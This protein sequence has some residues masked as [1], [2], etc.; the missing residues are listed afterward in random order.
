MA[1]FYETT[2]E[3]KIVN[4]LNFDYEV[5]TSLKTLIQKEIEELRKRINERLS[6]PLLEWYPNQIELIK[7]SKEN[8]ELNGISII[9]TVVQNIPQAVKELNQSIN[10]KGYLA[11]YTNNTAFPQFLDQIAIIKSNDQFGVLK[12]MRTS[13]STLTN[14]QNIE[15]LRKWD[16]V[17]G[18]E[19]LGAGE[20]WVEFRFKE[21][22][23][24]VDEF[25]VELKAFSP[26]SW[27]VWDKEELESVKDQ[28]IKDKL[29]E[30][31]I[32]ECWWEN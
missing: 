26:D 13:S 11:F 15:Q 25:L 31:N 16:Q 22:P 24:N 32:I 27:M 2:E 28:K 19:I 7:N 20:N 29:L 10:S 23:K 3:L 21:L 14:D 17:Y 1:S 9:G 4:Q 12:V 30:E 5:F 18:I 8:V 6:E